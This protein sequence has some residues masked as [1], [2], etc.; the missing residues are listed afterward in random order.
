M[1]H[2][3]KTNKLGFVEIKNFR[4]AKDSAKVMKRN[5]TDWEKIFSSHTLDKELV[6]RIRNELPR[7]K[8]K[9]KKNVKT[10]N[11]K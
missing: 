4:C 6:S 11:R 2:K 9:K 7:F 10:P 5:A 8:L 1:S 3:G